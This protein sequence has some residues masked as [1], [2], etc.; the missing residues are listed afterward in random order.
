MIRLLR[1]QVVIRETSR[2]S[3]I[4]HPDPKQRQVHTHRGT[5][6]GI[7]PPALHHGHEVIPEFR[8]GDDVSYH[9]SRHNQDAFTLPWPEDG[10]PATWVPQGDVDGVWEGEREGMMRNTFPSELP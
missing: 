3:I 10:K 7:G 1:G 8:V 5:V 4:W 9:F 6:L 2:P